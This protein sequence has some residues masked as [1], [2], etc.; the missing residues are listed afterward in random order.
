MLLPPQVIGASGVGGPGLTRAQRLALGLGSVVLPY[1]WSRLCRT[2]HAAE[3]PEAEAASWRRR[4]WRAMAWAEGLLQGASLVNSW[5][6][7]V[8]GDYR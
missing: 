4:A 6:F 1:A 7:L 5:A 8:R 2:A 3:W